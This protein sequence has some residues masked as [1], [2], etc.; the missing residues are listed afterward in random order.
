MTVTVSPRKSGTDHT[1]RLSPRLLQALERVRIRP[2]LR[3]AVVDGQEIEADDH[4]DLRRKLST[5]LYEVFHAGRSTAGDAV[6]FHIRDPR[7]EREL[8]ERVPHRE[9]VTRVVL[10]SDPEVSETSGRTVVVQRDGVRIRVAADRIRSE[11]ASVGAV[12]DMVVSPCR[13]ALS[14]GFFLVDGTRSVHSAGPILRLYVHLEKAEAALLVWEHVLRLLE[15]SQTPYRAKVLSS[16][17]LFPRSD[18]LVV[19]LRPDSA[20]I[21]RRIPAL[22][23]GVDGIGTR[24]SVFAVPISPG[25]AIARE[26]EDPRPH[27]R[28]LSFGQHR[29]GVLAQALVESVRDELPVEEVIGQQF[30]EARICA[31]E[32]ARNIGDAEFAES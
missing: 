14:P 26:P 22:L 18:G 6:P 23:R 20:H 10:C 21:A 1:G 5:T 27:M 30:T 16:D 7:L 8:A 25:V 32:P 13:A 11:G 3:G 15:E 24:T 31:S 17:V 9:T 28:G 29:A 19:Y 4:H 12:V 2:D